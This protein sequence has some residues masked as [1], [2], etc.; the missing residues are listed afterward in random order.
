MSYLDALHVTKLSAN[1]LLLTRKTTSV[2]KRK[3][4]L[5]QLPLKYKLNYY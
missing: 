4:K 2:A 1:D 3:Y 5:I